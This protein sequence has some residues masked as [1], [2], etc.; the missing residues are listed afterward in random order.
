MVRLKKEAVGQ[1]NY[2]A[3]TPADQKHRRYATILY[4][5]QT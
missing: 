1:F 4:L 3:P 5:P 2:L